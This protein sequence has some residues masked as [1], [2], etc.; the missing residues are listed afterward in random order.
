MALSLATSAFLQGPF[1]SNG[2]STANKNKHLQDANSLSSTN[3]KWSISSHQTLVS[4][5]FKGHI[6]PT[7]KRNFA[8]EDDI[9]GQ[10]ERRLEEVKQLF[11]RVR[12]D[13]LES[14]VMVDALQRLAIDYRFEDEIEALLQ[15]HF[16]ISTSRSHSHPIDAENLHEAA[17]R[18]RLLRQGG[19]PVPSDVF[20][21][22]LDKMN[23]GLEERKP[24]DNDILGLTSLFEASHLGTDGEDVLDEVRESIGQRLH[25]SLADLDHLQ[26]RLVRNSLGNPFHKSMA[27]FKANDFLSNL[28]GHSYGWTENLGELAHL[29]M[30]IVRS[31]H[32][33]EIL[34]ISNWWKELGMAKELKYARDQPIKWYMWPMAI[35]TD[36]GLSQER[37]A[38]AKTIS[39][40]YVIDDIF[41][42]YGTIDEL[43]SFTDVV[44]RWECTEKDNIP[45]YMR[46]CFH[47]LDDI[48]NEVSFVVHKNHG[49]NPLYSLRR[50]WAKLLNAFLVEARWLARGHYPT[51]QD[52]L[53]NAIVSSGVHVLLV[54][55]FFLLGERIDPESVHHLENIPEI[56]SSTASILRLWDDLGS[57]KDESQDGR[58]GS[59]LEC[60]KQEFQ[61][62]S[63][64]VARDRVKKMISE[65]WK[66]LNKACLYPHP[67]TKS[68]TK[69]ALNT[70][71]MVPLMYDYDDNHSLPLLEHHTKSL[72]YGGP[73]F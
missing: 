61:I 59:Y 4:T 20:Q 72:L 49:W 29:D 62:T 54:H 40:I 46:M 26:A 70:A 66:R 14:L 12:G 22:F 47:A 60:Y 7:G 51:T 52:Y 3:N 37:V 21:P 73:S 55:L 67:F 63:D 36:S 31:V 9:R 17:L 30:N 44:N 56:V 71:R 18:F 43:A 39:F 32:Q 50:T 28:G 8:V 15:R 65:A 45:E 19:Y 34:Q 35:L 13:S 27:R 42:V 58:D 6:H 41:D 1:A 38:A 69:A 68:F 64:E 5:P 48:T 16:L 11:K 57:A 33:R 10:H 53:D 24:Q 25:D 23:G 2:T